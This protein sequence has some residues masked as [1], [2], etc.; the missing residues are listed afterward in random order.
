MRT[1]KP[2]ELKFA[3]PLKALNG[4]LFVSRGCGIHP[5]RTIDSHELIF[6]RSGML[7]I[8]ED[9]QRFELKEGDA[10]LL[11]P[12]LRHGGTLAY[13]PDLSF[14]WIHF[15]IEKESKT[16]KSQQIEIPRVG[17]VA[18]PQRF[19]EL[20]LRFLDAQESD[21]GNRLRLSLLLALMLA[22]LAAAPKSSG[23][24]AAALAARASELIAVDSLDQD[25][26]AGRL[27]AKLRCNPDYLG[28]IFKAAY[29]YSLT[30]AI[31]NRRIAQARKLLLESN[32]NIGEIVG[33]SGFGDI[34]FFRRIFKRHTGFAPH[35]FRKLCPRR[36]INTE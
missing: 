11:R 26:S 35:S 29:G 33:A 17:R 32:L 20:C 22:E 16:T 3:F 13:P 28:R 14:F 7:G 24:E 19:A 15:L 10:L 6:V 21:P 18:E 36:H 2:L 23:P 30:R 9:K 5:T 1:D 12:G 8:F 27:A 4:G 31:H 34:A 25:F